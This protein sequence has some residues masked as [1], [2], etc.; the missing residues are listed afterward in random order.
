MDGGGQGRL[1]TLLDDLKAVLEEE[2][3]TLLSGMPAKLSVVTQRK[4]DLADA[5]EHE[6]QP[7]A[8]AADLTQL[9]ALARYNRENSVI[10][11]AI[12][13]HMTGALDRLRQHD[14]H[15]SYREDGSEQS[16]PSGRLVGAA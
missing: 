4:L 7:G 6:T 16:P 9:R 11:G 8:A 1:A 12:L 2:R 15:R 10:C 13:R 5:I 3:R 14:P